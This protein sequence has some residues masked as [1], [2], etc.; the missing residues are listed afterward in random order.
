[1]KY[2]SLTIAM[3]HSVTSMYMCELVVKVSLIFVNKIR[4]T[5]FF[6]FSDVHV[7]RI[8]IFFSKLWSIQ[9]NEL[10]HQTRGDAA[11]N[12]LEWHPLIMTTGYA[13]LLSFNLQRNYYIVTIHY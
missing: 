12:A 10:L 5:L 6:S 3:T 1:L 13:T 4:S 8:A 9:P 2:L 11:T 7:L